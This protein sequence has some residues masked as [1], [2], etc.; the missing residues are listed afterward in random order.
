MTTQN[1]VVDISDNT[2]DNNDKP[3][4]VSTEHV[5]QEEVK[6]E[7]VKPKA[8]AKPRGKSKGTS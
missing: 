4:V 6:Q 2:N 7:E 1:G 3:P 8:K 5:Q